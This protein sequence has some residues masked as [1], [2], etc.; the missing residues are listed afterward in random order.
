MA[1]TQ[2]QKKQDAAAKNVV[3]FIKFLLSSGSY[4]QSKIYY[5]ITLSMGNK[6]EPT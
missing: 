6:P 4:P 2:T 3:V 1:M 5:Y